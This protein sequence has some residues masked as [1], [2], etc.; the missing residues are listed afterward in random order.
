MAGVWSDLSSL[1]SLP[2]TPARSDRNTKGE[3]MGSI[4]STITAH[5]LKPCTHV[6][7]TRWGGWEGVAVSLDKGQTPAVCPHHLLARS[8]VHANWKAQSTWPGT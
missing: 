2:G 8:T 6:R 4:P 3:Q 7:R 1:L 5:L